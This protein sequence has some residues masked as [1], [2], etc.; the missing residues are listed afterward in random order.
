MEG[1]EGDGG[2]APVFDVGDDAAELAGVAGLER[3][4][5]GGE[6]GGLVWVL[7]VWGGVGG[8]GW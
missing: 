1:A 2:D 7:L 4:D 5:F 6:V 8:G 3:A